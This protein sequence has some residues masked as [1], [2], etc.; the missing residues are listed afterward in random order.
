MRYRNY[1][2]SVLPLQEGSQYQQVIAGP[3]FYR[4]GSGSQDISA[5]QNISVSMLFVND[6]LAEL[7]QPQAKHSD[8]LQFHIQLPFQVK[9]EQ[10]TDVLNLLAQYNAFLPL[11]RLSLDETGVSFRYRWHVYERNIDGLVFLD[12]LETQL[13]FI[14]RLGYRIEAVAQGTR[15]LADVL[16]DEIQFKN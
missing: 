7:N 14:E 2:A 4:T 11:G 5:Q 12:I 1:P 6:V 8:M 9:S 13:F 15:S 3:G 16:K 10:S